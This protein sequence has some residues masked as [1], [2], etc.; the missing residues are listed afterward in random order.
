MRIRMR[1]R[2]PGTWLAA[3]AAALA[4]SGLASAAEAPRREDRGD[5]VVLWVEGSYREMGRQQARLLGPDLVAVYELQR[6]EYERDV[7]AGGLAASL[8]DA[9]AVPVWSGLGRLYED[10]GL[11]EEIAGMAEV[12]GVPPREAM[13]AL[14]SLGG[15]TVFVATRGATADGQALVGRNVDWDDGAGS[16]RPVVVHYRP[17]TGEGGAGDDLAFVATGWPLVGMYTTGLNEAGLA[18]SFNYFLADELLATTFPEWPHRLAL[19]RARTVDEAIAIFQAPRT[20]GIA[21]FMAL[22]DAAGDIAL[23]ECTPDECVVFRPDADWFAHANHARTEAMIPRDHYRS[24]DSFTRRADMERAVER[25]LGALTPELAAR[26]VRDRSGHPH[27]N[28]NSVGNPAVLNAVVIHPA[29]RVLWH[30]TTMQPLAA[31]GAYAPFS[32]SGEASD[33]PLLPPDPALANGAFAR[34]A[35]VMGRARQALQSVLAGDLDAARAGFEEVLGDP[36]LDPARTAL[37]VAWTRHARGD[38]QGAFDVL[39]PAVEGG[40]AFDARAYGLVQRALLADALGRRD[41]AL[42]LYAR[43]REHLDARPE[44][45][46]FGALRERIAAGLAEPQQAERLPVD[47]YVVRIPH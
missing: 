11:H 5:L 8:F 32:P 47:W 15:S 30:S 25:H 28:D 16:R 39:A 40:A 18:V 24:P 12:L 14:M 45:N 6:R 1:L 42:A 27:A 13:R 3:A 23:L 38:L 29:R 34:E 22:A 4:C 37:A 9:V 33:A 17:R 46:V 36:V 41:E 44:F 7:D 35:E 26:V 31:F 43:A 2:S 20:L 21:T 10:S 19:Q